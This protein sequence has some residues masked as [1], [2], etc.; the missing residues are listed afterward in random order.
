MVTAA[1]PSDGGDEEDRKRAEPFAKS[2]EPFNL[3]VRGA[4]SYSGHHDRA[5]IAALKDHERS[6]IGEE[7]Q[8]H[9]GLGQTTGASAW[10]GED[11]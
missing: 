9:K 2:P 11:S 8:L 1:T 5:G 10:L 6:A 4:N 7:I 3:T